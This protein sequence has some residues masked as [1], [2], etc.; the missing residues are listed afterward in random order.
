MIIFFI[1]AF[2]VLLILF[3]SIFNRLI[4]LKNFMLEAFSGIDVQL[5]RR[6]DLIPDIVDC[7]KGYAGHESGLLENVAL[8]RGEVDKKK[9]I[10][11][12]GEAEH[13][14]SRALRDIFFLAEGY[15]E[16][17]AS[18]NFLSLQK[19][20]IEIEDQIQLARRYYNGTVRNYNTGLA[21]FPN[22]V[23]ARL[24]HFE[25]ADFFEID[26]ATQRK[27]PDVDFNP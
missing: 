7:V 22:L 26:Y 12:K 2:I 13:G 6:H 19:T 15:P 14:I 1:S 24:F 5:K 17:K 25:P 20:L 23:A 3:I 10:K 9:T 16:L 27:A 11:E 8:L 18:E 21:V 4:H